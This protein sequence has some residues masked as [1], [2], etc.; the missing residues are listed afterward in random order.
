VV[1]STRELFGTNNLSERNV[2]HIVLFCPVRIRNSF[3]WLVRKLLFFFLHKSEVWTTVK[4]RDVLGYK[5][6]YLSD[7]DSVSICTP[8]TPIM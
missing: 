8:I 7:K 2:Q 5:G 6:E 4:D 1:I 3:F